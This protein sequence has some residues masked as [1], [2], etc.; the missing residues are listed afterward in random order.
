MRTKRKTRIKNTRI[1]NTRIKNTRIKRQ[2][3]GEEITKNNAENRIFKTDVGGKTIYYIIPNTLILKKVDQ[4]RIPSF[5]IKG[6]KVSIQIGDGKFI[7]YLL[8][9]DG[10]IYAIMRLYGWFNINR[11]VFAHWTNDDLFIEINPETIQFDPKENGTIHS[12]F[13]NKYYTQIT[14]RYT[15]QD[16]DAKVF[17]LQPNTFK[18]VNRSD[19]F[20]NTLVRFRSVE[21]LKNDVKEKILQD[22]LHFGIN[23]LLNR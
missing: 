12:I 23:T 8:Y 4:T 18:K 16:P 17:Q 10:K 21:I 22:G 5:N 9:I 11:G 2:K 14:K 6:K 1:K 13:S 3:G 15:L 7:D 19:T 20:Y